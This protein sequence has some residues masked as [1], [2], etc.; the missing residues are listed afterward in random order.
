MTPDHADSVACGC[1]ADAAVSQHCKNGRKLV[2]KR[3]KNDWES[4]GIDAGQAALVVAENLE[5]VAGQE[6]GSTLASV[7]SMAA[8]CGT[9]SARQF[10]DIYS[11]YVIINVTIPI[12]HSKKFAAQ[13]HACGAPLSQEGVVDSSML[14]SPVISK[15]HQ[16]MMA[17]TSAPPRDN[18]TCGL[19]GGQHN[20][21]PNRLIPT[22]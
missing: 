22:A 4:K 17:C 5:Q 13:V 10:S 12:G 19:A 1:I 7:P 3:F 15:V 14:P 16:M 20:A 8:G 11:A 9:L 18:G 6:H 2:I 21:N